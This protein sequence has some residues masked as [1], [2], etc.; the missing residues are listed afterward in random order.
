MTVINN[1]EIDNTIQEVDNVKKSIIHNDPIDSVLHIVCMV[2]N[3]CQYAR[4]YILAREF[5]RRMESEENV[6]LY[7]VE[8]CYSSQKP[9]VADIK[10]KKH[11][12]IK[13]ESPPLWHKEN[14]I[15]IGIDKL[16][17]ANWKAVAWIDMDIQFDSAHW[18]LD[19]L[20][21]L[22][23]YA[24]VV[25]LFS[26]ALDLN[27]DFSILNIFNSYGYQYERKAK[28]VKGDNKNYYHPGYAWA[29]TRKAYHKMGKLYDLSILGSGDNNMAQC[30][31][32]TASKTLDPYVN[33]NYLN[34]VLELQKRMKNL[35]L[36]YVPGTIRHFFHGQKKN[37]KYTERWK[38]LVKWQY[39]PYKHLVKNNQDL[40]VPT[41]D[42]P[43]GL[44]DDIMKYF[45]E[46]NEDEFYF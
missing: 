15:N 30:F 18:A 43:I 26:Q 25:Q 5:V 3:P 7:I 45:I 24:D 42:C 8:I 36:S 21:L 27:Y 28:Y 10:N 40:L 31:S 19:C 22:N 4:R 29:C 20:K 16:L 6:E 34:S 38:L 35:R 41:K 14:A 39:D 32:G 9:R 37:R 1:I 33:E 12:I 17:P 2:S 23:G 13:T 44:L 46:R 11:L